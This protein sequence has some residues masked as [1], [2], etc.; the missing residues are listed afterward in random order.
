MLLKEN[1][2]DQGRNSLRT[3]TQRIK[4][5]YG[6]TIQLS[7]PRVRPGNSQIKKKL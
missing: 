7:F 1:I 3:G 4:E 2:W 5:K 6:E